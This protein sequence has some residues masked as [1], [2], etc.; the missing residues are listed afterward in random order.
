[1]KAV[2]TESWPR[3]RGLLTDGFR[4]ALIGYH[5]GAG[6]F[7]YMDDMG[8]PLAAG[9]EL[10]EWSEIA[11]PLSRLIASM[12]LPH[13][14]SETLLFHFGLSK[15]LARDALRAFWRQLT[16]SKSEFTNLL[17]AQWREL[18]ALAAEFTV[19][20]TPGE[21]LVELFQMGR[22]ARSKSAW[23]QAVFVVH[24]YYSLLL[25]LLALRIVDDL[26]LAGRESQL[27]RVAESPASAMF[28]AEHRV[29][30]V[31]GNVIE[32][33]VFSWSCC[34][35]EWPPTKEVS[36]AIA[37]MAWRMKSFDVHGVRT[38]V[39]RRLYQNIIPPKL[40][41]S[42]GEFYTPTRAAELVL[43][44]AGFEGK[45]RLLDP[46]CGSGTFLVAA[47]H[48]ILNKNS[49]TAEER[50]STVSKSVVGYDLNP[51][52]VATARLNDVL[53][54]VDTLRSG[55]IS[56]PLSIPVFLADSLL[57]LK[58]SHPDY[59]CISEFPHG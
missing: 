52:A 16:E 54:L 23:D 28:D 33:D 2:P 38:D 46:T 3:H 40:R 56:E 19:A 59:L 6:K 49:G 58:S 41:K 35:K 29:P 15:P 31:L 14:D 43:N 8:M 51:I 47:I 12:G 26:G 53:A 44:E 45:G 10:L 11:T 32:R 7:V 30:E 27:D 36:M 1:M 22:H 39:L 17:F 42:L 24:T 57:Y 55:I 5:A 48:R 20:E 50:L 9:R 13:L 18:F 34:D 37:E 4:C 25:K 21:D